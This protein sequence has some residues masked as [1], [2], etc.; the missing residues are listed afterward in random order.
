M[1]CSNKTMSLKIP[2]EVGACVIRD[3]LS[4]KPRDNIAHDNLVSTG[5]VSDMVRPE[6]L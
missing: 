1:Q 5:A 6:R 3:W 4:D 2:N